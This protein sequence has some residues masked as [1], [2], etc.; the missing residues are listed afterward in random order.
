MEVSAEGGVFKSYDSSV[1]KYD[2]GNDLLTAAENEENYCGENEDG[3]KEYGFLATKEIS[4]PTPEMDGFDFVGWVENNDSIKH[5]E[6]PTIHS[7]V[8]GKVGDI[9]DVFY[10]QVKTEIPNKDHFD[11]LY[12]TAVWKDK[13]QLSPAANLLTIKGYQGAKLGWTVSELKTVNGEPTRIASTPWGYDAYVYNAQGDAYENF[14]VVYVKEDVKED[15]VVG[16]ATLSRNFVY[17]SPSDES[18]TSYKKISYGGSPLGSDVSSD[19][20]YGGGSIYSY[21]ANGA[22]VILCKDTV[23]GKGGIYGIQIF[24]SSL[25]GLAKHLDIKDSKNTSTRDYGTEVEKA[26]ALELRDWAISYRANA[27][28]AQEKTLTESIWSGADNSALSAQ[29][30]SLTAAN[31]TQSGLID[32]YS[33]KYYGG[34]V[35]AQFSELKVQGADAFGCFVGALDDSDNNARR[36]QYLTFVPDDSTSYYIAGGFSDNAETGKPVGVLHFFY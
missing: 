9:W 7:T 17:Y 20:G 36:Y 8:S 34:K 16:M 23:A 29:A 24:D 26:Q 10:N 6:Q 13:D 4:L 12:L 31:E 15:V 18:N 1:W 27:L 5:P 32:A 2:E 21:S 3:E 14:F 25:G 28:L 19:Y 22:N 35:K 33:E 30:A 11:E